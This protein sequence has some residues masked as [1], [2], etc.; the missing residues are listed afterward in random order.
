MNEYTAVYLL[1]E[2]NMNL[3]RGCKNSTHPRGGGPVLEPGGVSQV[4]VGVNTPPPVGEVDNAL[5][6]SRR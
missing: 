5:S 3:H 4:L 2:N 1:A 6:S